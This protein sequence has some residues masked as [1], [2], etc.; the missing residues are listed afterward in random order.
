M[1]STEPARSV[2][3]GARAVLL[4]LAD[5]HAEVQRELATMEQ[6]QTGPAPTA[7]RWAYVRWK[8]SRA[9]RQRRSAAEQ[10]Y[11]LVLSAATLAER[12]RIGLLQAQDP[13][14]LAASRD[15]IATWTPDRI[16][17]DWPGYCA[18]SRVIRRSMADRVQAEQDVLIP[19]LT[20]LV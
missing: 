12:V 8:L 4:A 14:M 13:V 17:A 2:E 18:A 3:T 16:T 5:A 20:R 7:E 10:A 19:I 15:H 1:Q 11:P 9:S 6:I